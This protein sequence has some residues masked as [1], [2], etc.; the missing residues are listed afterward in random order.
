MLKHTIC[1]YNEL[2][3]PFQNISKQNQSIMFKILVV[4][5]QIYKTVH[6]MLNEAKKMLMISILKFMTS[7][8]LQCKS[9]LL[10]FKA[11]GRELVWINKCSESISKVK[12][13]TN[14]F[15]KITNGRKSDLRVL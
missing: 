6:I 13:Q 7:K 3:L 12:F 15:K 14:N 10:K 1:T 9:S 2:Y 4:C 11:K 8:D 5:M